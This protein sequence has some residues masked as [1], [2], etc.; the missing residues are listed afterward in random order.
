MKTP[1]LV[2][3]RIRRIYFDAIVQGAKNREVRRRC[4]FWDIRVAAVKARHTQ[5]KPVV[6]MF[7]CGQDV[8]QRQLVQVEEFPTAEAALG[9]SPSEQGKKDLGDGPVWVFH[10]GDEIPY[11]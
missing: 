4:P 2:V 3:F 6:A 9:R 7:L 5:H 10:L 1:Y 8:H 11:P